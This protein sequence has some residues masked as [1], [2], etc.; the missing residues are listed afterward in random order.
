MSLKLYK[1]PSVMFATGDVTPATR[2]QMATVNG[3]RRGGGTRSRKRSKKRAK[4]ASGG[5]TK[6][7]RGG[8]RKRLRKGS[9]E[10]KAYMAKIRKMRK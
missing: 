3:T 8:S 10:A 1:K 6:R 4:R 7:K 5:G 9:A 2:A